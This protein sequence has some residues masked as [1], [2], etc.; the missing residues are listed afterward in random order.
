MVLAIA[1]AG[2]IFITWHIAFVALAV[3]LFS[4]V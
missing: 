1:K 4:A 2:L 3:M